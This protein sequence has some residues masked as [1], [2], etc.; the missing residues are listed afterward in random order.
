M[1]VYRKTTAACCELGRIFAGCVPAFPLRFTELC[2]TVLK[3]ICRSAAVPSP[4]SEGRRA[5]QTRSS[6]MQE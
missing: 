5:D 2:H 3:P 4:S 6:V 1:S